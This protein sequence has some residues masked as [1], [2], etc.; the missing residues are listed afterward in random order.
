LR[1]LQ[2]RDLFQAGFLPDG[3]FRWRAPTTY[4]LIQDAYRLQKKSERDLKFLVQNCLI[5]VGSGAA[6]AVIAM[7]I[8]AAKVIFRL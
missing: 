8:I 3:A 2:D 4:E 7:V 5:V 1:G 6:G